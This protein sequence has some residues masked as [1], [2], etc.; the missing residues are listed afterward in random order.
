[1]EKEKKI[2][3]NGNVKYEGEYTNG[4]RN[5]KGKEFYENGKKNLK[6]NF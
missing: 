6:V 1:M 3:K 2:I 5:G 4:Q